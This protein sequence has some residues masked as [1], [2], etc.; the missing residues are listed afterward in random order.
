MRTWQCGPNRYALPLIVLVFKAYNTVHI[1]WDKIYRPHSPIV[2]SALRRQLNEDSYRHIFRHVMGHFLLFHRNYIDSDFRINCDSVMM[3]GIFF[4]F[5]KLLF[6]VRQFDLTNLHTVLQ[7][8]PL[9]L[10]SDSWL[11]L[12][13][14]KIT[15]DGG[16]Y[17]FLKEHAE[18]RLR[19]Q[20]SQCSHSSGTPS[21]WPPSPP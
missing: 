19:Q 2:C 14:T 18:V 9:P 15:D 7:V 3:Y 20:V 11:A 4:A 5:R 12:L 17:V 1:F 10:E 8:G 21:N 16:V 13:A 6:L